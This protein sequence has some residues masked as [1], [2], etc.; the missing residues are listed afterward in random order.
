MVVITILWTLKNNKCAIK[1]KI[2]LSVKLTYS[3]ARDNIVSHISNRDVSASSYSSFSACV[4]ESIDLYVPDAQLRKSRVPWEDED[5]ADLRKSKIDSQLQY[6]SLPSPEIKSYTT[7]FV[8][9]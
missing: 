8:R 3:T 2:K 4:K 5:I 9:I 6:M 7:I 1:K